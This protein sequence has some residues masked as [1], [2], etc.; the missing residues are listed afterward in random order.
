VGLGKYTLR[1]WKTN[2]SS[3][4]ATPRWL[5]GMSTLFRAHQRLWSIAVAAANR[6]CICRD[7]A[8]ESLARQVQAPSRQQFP[9]FGAKTIN[10]SVYRGLNRW[11]W[12]SF[13]FSALMLLIFQM[14]YWNQL[15]GNNIVV[16][17]SDL[18]GNPRSPT[19]N[20]K[21]GFSNGCYSFLILRFLKLTTVSRITNGH[22]PFAYFE[23][24]SYGN[25]FEPIYG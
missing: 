21:L 3:I 20:A 13:C 15:E 11:G 2:F 17:G 14:V 19:Y 8:A 22:I 6:T 23:K 9:P 10:Q 24:C 16:S 5:M 4:P 25:F 1:I 12:S 18:S 7:F